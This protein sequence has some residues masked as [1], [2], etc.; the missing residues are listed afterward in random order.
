MSNHDCFTTHN[1]EDQFNSLFNSMNQ[2]LVY[3]MADGSISS[4]N[5]AA[6]EILGL[7]ED[8]ILGRTS[9]D[10]GL[11]AIQED[12]SPFPDELHPAIRTLKTG[13]TLKDV[14]MGV[15]HPLEK[16]I[17][18]L[19][20]DSH[21]EFR[22]GEE[23]PF[24]VFTIFTDITEKFE[25]RQ[26]LQNSEEKFRNIT[27]NSFDLIYRYRQKPEPGFDYVSPSAERITGYTPE[28]HYQD[29]F[30]GMKLIHPDDLDV[31]RE[32][33]AGRVK[34]L[35]LVLRWQKKDGSIIWT[36]TTLKHEYDETGEISVIHGV[37][38]DVTEKWVAEQAL[39]ASSERIHKYFDS[40][41]VGIFVTDVNGFYTDVNPAGCALYE[42]SKDEIVGTHLSNY[43]AEETF[44]KGVG[45]FGI[46]SESGEYLDEFIFKTQKGRK[47]NAML[48]AIRFSETEFIGYVW[49]ITEYRNSQKEL[50]RAKETAEEASRLKTNILLNM[51]HEL[52]TPLFGV[53]GLSE[54]IYDEVSD[55][56][57]KDIAGK[58]KVAASRLLNTFN[59]ILDFSTIGA[60]EISAGFSEFD[61]VHLVRETGETYYD[62]AADKQLHFNISIPEVKCP[63][64][65]P[66]NSLQTALGH[67]LD[68]AFKYTSKGEVLLEL[69]LP[70]DNEDL[71]R[72][73]VK[74]TGIGIAVE[75]HQN[76][77]EE[78]RQVSEGLGRN[79]EGTGLGLTVARKIVQ[80]L[81]GDI[82]VVST[83]GFGSTFT[84]ELPCARDANGKIS[85]SFKSR[86]NEVTITESGIEGS[87][88]LLVLETNLM[89]A[90]VL[91]SLIQDHYQVEIAFEL[92]AFLQKIEENRYDALLFALSKENAEEISELARMIRES[93]E[94]T[95]TPMLAMVPVMP[96][97]VIPNPGVDV[98][99]AI[100]IKPFF[101]KD[102]L[103][104][105]KYLLSRV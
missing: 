88:R 98:F 3:H 21:P 18:W 19:S 84:L 70:A 27:E 54:I 36:E 65:L 57:I 46:L 59:L 45:S 29:P 82:T 64:I 102:I 91:K 92:Q 6:L 1:F 22:E 78:F 24:R 23:K 101:K 61:L 38:R 11:K 42:A 56:A 13:E 97:E 7:T 40:V 34:E 25:T 33:I 58:L 31:L 68:N 28:E 94:N 14:V 67:L 95:L 37:S 71:F 53:S 9:Y 26:M 35:P 49:D 90:E 100:L 96:G 86:T 75:D 76:I 93:E 74:D 17:R 66:R 4:A 55:P 79:F 99:D 8:Q 10:P 83:P 48:S 89:S 81:G 87:A 51:S 104:A 30:L 63:V 103:R 20:I 105:V 15:Y 50:Q 85:S 77:F 16:E 12:G 5:K 39:K 43:V 73:E 52:R 80:N 32:A 69:K 41:P 47:F 2:G 62:L 72:I 60:K 44:E